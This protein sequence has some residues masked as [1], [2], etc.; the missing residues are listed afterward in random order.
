MGIREAPL[1]FVMN[2][3]VFGKSEGG[4]GFQGQQSRCFWRGLGWKVEGDFLFVKRLGWY[5]CLCI[6]GVFQNRQ[7]ALFP[8]LPQ[9]ELG[10]EC[11]D[12]F[13]E[14]QSWKGPQRTPVSPNPCAAEKAEAQRRREEGSCLSIALKWVRRIWVFW[15]AKV[16]LKAG[17]LMEATSHCSY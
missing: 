14:G 11:A 10:V 8:P 2:L 13:L 9:P 12:G 6:Q 17:Y 15:L 16:D 5:V 7:K 1:L 3:V 4:A